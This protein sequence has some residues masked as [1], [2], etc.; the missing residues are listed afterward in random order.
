M[1]F[2]SKDR[3]QHLFYEHL[4][5]RKKNEVQERSREFVKSIYLHC[6]LVQL[7]YIAEVYF[8]LEPKPIRI[9]TTMQNELYRIFC[10]LTTR[11]L[12]FSIQERLRQRRPS[13]AQQEDSC[14]YCSQTAD[15]VMPKEYEQYEARL[16]LSICLGHNDDVFSS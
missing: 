14:T 10:R 12:C 9:A 1:Y 8:S 11:D 7:E 6:F 13:A 3:W 5:D 4:K 2:V 16:F 15:N